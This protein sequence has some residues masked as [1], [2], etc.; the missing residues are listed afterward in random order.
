MGSGEARQQEEVYQEPG[1]NFRSDVSQGRQ[2]GRWSQKLLIK[3]LKR[4]LKMR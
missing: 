3:E 1:G 4:R 2:L